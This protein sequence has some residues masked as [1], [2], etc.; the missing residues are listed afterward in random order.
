MMKNLILLI[1]IALILIPTSSFSQKLKYGYINADK[2]LSEMPEIA[3]AN[4]ELEGY[5][6]QI[7]D[8]INSK[9]EDYKK[10]LTEFQNNQASLSDLIKQDK[11]NELNNIGND[12][13]LFQQNAQNEINK[14]KQ[15]LYQPTIDKLKAAI[16]SVAKENGLRFV[17][18][19]SNGQLLYSEE[20]DNIDN[21]VRKKLG[22]P[23]K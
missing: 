16:S 8:Y 17:I 13:K 20:A 11:Q 1:F 23:V 5:I 22:L 18:D 14:K 12:I 9:S 15:D 21:L 3:V 6:K 10:K 4:K 2:I 7:N 19:N